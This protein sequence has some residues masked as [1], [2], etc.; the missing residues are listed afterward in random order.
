M[1][2]SGFSGGSYTESIPVNPV[3]VCVKGFVC[4]RSGGG[5]VCVRSAV[6]M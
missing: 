4:V 6:C 3:S 5:V 1:E 2:R